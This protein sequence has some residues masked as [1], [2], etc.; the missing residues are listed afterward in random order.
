MFVSRFDSSNLNTLDIEELLIDSKFYG[1]NEVTEILEVMKREIRFIA[2]Y[3][4]GPYMYSGKPLAQN[5]IEDFNDNIIRN[6][7][8]GI[9]AATPGWI[10]F[11]L[12]YENDIKSIEIGGYCG[13]INV[14]SAA[15]GNGA[16]ISTSMDNKSFVEVGVIPGTFGKTI[17]N[18]ALK[19]SRGKY[20]KIHHNSLLGIGYLKV[21]K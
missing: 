16:K 4:N 17:I 20:I 13:N 21:H 15:N 7:N 6:Q 9:V 19:L 12:N 5:N 18:I 14:F 2:F 3:Y 11:E 1:F 10:T 8:K